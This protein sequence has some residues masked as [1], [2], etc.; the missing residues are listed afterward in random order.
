[1]KNRSI[2]TV[3][4]LTFITFGIYGIIWVVKTKSEM[5]K[6]GAQIP[7]ALLIIVPFVN[8]YWIWKYA[9]GV[10][11]VT[12]GRLINAVA[13]LLILTLGVVGL[14]VLQNEFNNLSVVPV[15]NPVVPAPEPVNNLNNNF[16]V[17]ESQKDLNQQPFES[18]A[19]DEQESF[20]SADQIASVES[21]FDNPESNE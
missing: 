2:A 6:L 5:N 17:N 15:M 13:F 11:F 20:Q 9:E 21:T 8:I 12:K 3:L 4:L 18:A 19:Q 10:E 14:A 7:T 16:S 1:M